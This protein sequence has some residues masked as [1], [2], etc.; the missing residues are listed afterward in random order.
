M[1]FVYTKTLYYDI[2]VFLKNSGY[3]YWLGF[4]Y[5]RG[6]SNFQPTEAL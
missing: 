2:R 5:F 3:I 1:H 4:V 6:I